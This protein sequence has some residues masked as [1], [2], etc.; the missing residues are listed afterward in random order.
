M[1]GPRK[2]K[3]KDEG[4]PRFQMCAQSRDPSAN[5]PEQ[6]NQEG[7][8]ACASRTL[9]CTTAFLNPGGVLAPFSHGHKYL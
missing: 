6:I 3:V 9:I 4:T 8:K 1:T 5:S 7:N 2:S